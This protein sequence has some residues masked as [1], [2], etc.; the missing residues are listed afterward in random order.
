MTI[1]TDKILAWHF[2]GD[3]L[4]DGRPIPADGEKLIHEGKLELCANGFHASENILDA[5]I[6]APGFTCCRVELSGE[7]IKDTDKLVASERTILWRVEAKEIIL[8]FAR[9]C[10][11]D[12]V[13][14][15][16]APEIVKQFL[17]SGDQN[18]AKDAATAAYD[19]AYDAA[20][21]AA[22]NAAA[23]A[24]YAAAHAAYADTA[25][26]AATGAYAAN[27]A[28]HAAAKEEYSQKLQAL[29]EAA[30]V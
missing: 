5:L 9:D 16:N 30:H 2:V 8:K 19:A 20:A 29:I 10:A 6:Y 18:L 13:H 11:L 24:A 25:A 3:K 27:A 12:V 28:A 14:L 21:N 17:S 26:Y 15:W 1:N 7:I 23:Y 22:A 4:R